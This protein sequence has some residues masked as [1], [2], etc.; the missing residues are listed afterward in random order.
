MA[1]SSRH[2]HT[3]MHPSVNDTIRP[4]QDQSGAK[5][6]GTV[7]PDMLR[8]MLETNCDCELVWQEVD[9]IDCFWRMKVQDGTEHIV[10]FQ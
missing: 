3:T 7:R 8:F 2:Q 4:A 6:I 10:V 1:S 9:L 5:R